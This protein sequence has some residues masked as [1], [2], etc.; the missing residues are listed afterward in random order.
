MNAKISHRALEILADEEL[1]EKVVEALHKGESRT[2]I[3]HAGRLITISRI[4]PL[5][6]CKPQP[7]TARRT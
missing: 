3:K 2:S 6:G 5:S 1:S 7:Q 4:R